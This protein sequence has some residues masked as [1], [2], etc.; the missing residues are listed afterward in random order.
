MNLNEM[1]S[2]GNSEFRGAELNSDGAIVDEDHSPRVRQ[3]DRTTVTLLTRL[4]VE[5]VTK[6]EV[7]RYD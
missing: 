6:E 2:V 4:G 1:A 3:L 7:T 5:H